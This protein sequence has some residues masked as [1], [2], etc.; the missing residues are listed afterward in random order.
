MTG[1]ADQDL[2]QVA[3]NIFGALVQYGGIH[4]PPHPQLTEFLSDDIRA[5][6][7]GETIS[8]VLFMLEDDDLYVRRRA[9]DTYIILVKYG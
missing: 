1:D 4:I 3:L 2:R 5:S 6:L 8:K 7:R 9:L